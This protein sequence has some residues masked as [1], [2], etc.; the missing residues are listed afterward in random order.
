[1]RTSYIV[2]AMIVALA[3]CATTKPVSSIS[4]PSLGHWQ[5]RKI[6]ELVMTIG[7]FDAT[8]IHR[9]SRSYDWFRFGNCHLQALTNLD[10]EIQKL[11]LEGTG[12]GCDV[13]LD[14][15]RG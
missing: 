11:E 1:M 3:S 4:S 14:K 12:T 8:S 7:P 6:S 9:D 5:T 10:G 13:Y 15:L 2:L